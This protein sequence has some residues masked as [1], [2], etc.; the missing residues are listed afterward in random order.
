MSSKIH[1]H[2]PMP[3]YEPD[4]GPV[5]ADADV[6][7]IDGD[8]Y[9]AVGIELPDGNG[10]V[11]FVRR[12]QDAAVIAGAFASAARALLGDAVL[13]TLELIENVP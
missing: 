13:E 6:R 7:D 5:R 12:P 4:A 8:P 2:L 1:Y 10:L 9:V 3:K 11:L